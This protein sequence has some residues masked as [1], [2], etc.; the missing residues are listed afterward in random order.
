MRG[1]IYFFLLLESD[2][3]LPG[4]VGIMGSGIML[5][6]RRRHSFKIFV[7]RV[8]FDLASAS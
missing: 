1:V 5:D 3:L 4:D 7:T 8:R 6:A 2:E